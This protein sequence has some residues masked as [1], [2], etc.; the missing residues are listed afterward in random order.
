[1]L[2]TVS[3]VAAVAG[4]S[5]IR[6]SAPFGER[7]SLRTRLHRDHRAQQRPVHAR[8]QRRLRDQPVVQGRRRSVPRQ[9]QPRRPDDQARPARAPDRAPART[10]GTAARC[11]RPPGQ[12][13]RAMPDI[14]LGHLHAAP[15]PMGILV[16]VGLHAAPRGAS[17]APAA[18]TS[19]AAQPPTRARKARAPRR[20]NGW[21]HG[22]TPTISGKARRAARRTEGLMLPP[23][24]ACRSCLR[25]NARSPAQIKGK[26]G[27]AL[28]LLADAPLHKMPVVMGMS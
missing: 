5:C 3:S 11:A 27:T 21:R 6:P 20:K 4:I 22:W 28:R 18:R 16:A 7:A 17:A 19:S 25:T 14:A 2:S 26:T 23:G 15:D 9:S 12:G 24:R 1:M 10:S 13:P 8:I